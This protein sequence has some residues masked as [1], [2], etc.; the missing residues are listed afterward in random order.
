MRL[1]PRMFHSLQRGLLGL[2]LLRASIQSCGGQTL[3]E[4][5]V[6]VQALKRETPCVIDGSS[7]EWAEG[8]VVQTV[9]GNDGKTAATFALS[10]DHQALYAFVRVMDDSPLKNG[11]TVTEEL[12]KGGDALGL[13]FGPFRNDAIGADGDLS[14]DEQHFLA[15]VDAQPVRPRTRRRHKLCRIDGFVVAHR[16]ALICPRGRDSLPGDVSFR[17]PSAQGLE[18]VA[19][20]VHRLERVLQITVGMTDRDEAA[21]LRQN[22]QTLLDDLR[23]HGA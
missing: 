16:S 9:S 12:L 6:P 1:Y 2:C 4:E 18:A 10:Y 22:E 15:G 21:V 19:G 11:A 20:A 5:S 23:F 8:Q 7:A 14:R 17:F 3:A 13:C